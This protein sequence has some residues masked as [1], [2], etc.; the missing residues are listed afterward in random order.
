M[1]DRKDI[2]DFYYYSFFFFF[3]VIMSYVHWLNT[4]FFFHSSRFIWDLCGCLVIACLLYICDFYSAYNLC[5]KIKLRRFLCS[6][7]LDSFFAHSNNRSTF[8]WKYFSLLKTAEK[9]IKQKKIFVGFNKL[10]SHSGPSG[11]Y[12][13]CSKFSRKIPLKFI[14]ESKLYFTKIDISL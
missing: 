3:C 10:F 4:G 12:L 1:K 13:V 2:L 5:N 7:L 8:T 11:H 6:F 14:V 9:R